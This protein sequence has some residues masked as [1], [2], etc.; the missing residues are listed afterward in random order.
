MPTADQPVTDADDA[1]PIDLD[2]PF[3]AFAAAGDW[4]FNTALEVIRT[5]PEPQAR[6]IIRTSL[7]ALKLASDTALRKEGIK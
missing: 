5:Y 7:R 6:R 3:E 2:D 4:W 1:E